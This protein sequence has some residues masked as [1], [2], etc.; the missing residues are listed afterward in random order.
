MHCGCGRPNLLQRC[1]NL[2][3]SLRSRVV[4]NASPTNPET[5]IVQAQR[6]LH[7]LSNHGARKGGHRADSEIRLGAKRAKAE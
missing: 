7:A 6:D 2:Q 3:V 4:L 1:Q 5:S